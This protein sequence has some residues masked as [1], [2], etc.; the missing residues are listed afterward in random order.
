MR[1]DDFAHRL[2]QACEQAGVT[3]TQ[4]AL[5]K[6]FGVSGTMARYYLTG[7]KLPSTDTAILIAQ[8][9]GCQV[10]WLL[11]GRGPAHL[12]HDDLLD[13]SG[14]PAASK[15]AIRALVDTLR[16]THRQAA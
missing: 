9:L 4:Q 15:H 12:D 8:R 3:M 1:Y 11:T 14:L 16:T 7:E 10:E 6:L 13:I 5:G 2:R